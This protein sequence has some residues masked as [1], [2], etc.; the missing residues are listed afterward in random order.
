[1]PISYTA[2]SQLKLDDFFPMLDYKTGKTYAP[3]TG[4]PFKDQNQLYAARHYSKGATAWNPSSWQDIYQMAEKARADAFLANQFATDIILSKE[5]TG[6]TV[7]D[8]NGQ[9]HRAG[10]YLY[11]KHSLNAASSWAGQA[12]GAP[13]VKGADGN[14]YVAHSQLDMVAEKGLKRVGTGREN[15]SM[16]ETT[17]YKHG[18][19]GSFGF[20]P[21]ARITDSDLIRQLNEGVYAFSSKG[22]NGQTVYVPYAV[23]HELKKESGGRPEAGNYKNDAAQGGANR[24]PRTAWTVQPNVVGDPLGMKKGLLGGVAASDAAQR[25]RTLLG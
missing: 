15:H 18:N 20:V 21:G 2:Q 6:R 3:N 9:S 16:V 1:M 5:A 24:E 22:A 11:N 19:A 17:F 8:L 10:G 4:D 13:A 25:S 23:G 7:Y 14:W 12:F